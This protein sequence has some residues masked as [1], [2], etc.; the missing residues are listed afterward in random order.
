[1]HLLATVGWPV[2]D[3]IPLM[4]GFGIS[5][6]GLFIAI[7][8]VA[9]VLW[10]LREGPKRGMSVEHLSTMILV[11]LVGA[12]VGARF[13]YVLAH[14]EDFDSIG[15]TIQ[16]WRGGVSLL[17]G[18][19]GAVIA[20]IPLMRRYHYRFFQTMDSASVAL[21][22]GIFVGRIGDLIAGD[23][24]GKPTSWLLGFTYEG[25]TPF[26]ATCQQGVGC[27]LPLLRGERFLSL[28]EQ[29]AS[30]LGKG[31]GLI[32][33]G[34]GVHQTALYD[35][36]SAGVLF[37]VLFL[38][39]RRPRREGILFCTFLLWYG[40]TRILEDFLRV[41]KTFF[42]LTG[43]QWASI[44]AAAAAASLLIWWAIKAK[45][46]GPLDPRPSAAFVAPME[47]GKV[48]RD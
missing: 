10:L 48:A 9:G 39:S 28:N 27:I 16:I 20:N 33:Q 18:I 12:I 17:G 22:F 47:P 41:E 13:F 45:I 4:G 11:A 38:L 29:G 35:M 34:L 21:A 46:K 7:G 31:G 36:A 43:S 23:R 1:M 6:R 26:G 2:I 30:L 14:P 42:G 40:V 8:F 44:A 25:G 19:A 37:L 15:A 24:L 3:R 32:S 5:P